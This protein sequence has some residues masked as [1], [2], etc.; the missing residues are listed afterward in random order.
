MFLFKWC[1]KYADVSPAVRELIE[2]C[3]GTCDIWFC[4]QIF[5]WLWFNLSL[6]KSLRCEQGVSTKLCQ[7]QSEPFV[8]TVKCKYLHSN[9]TGHLSYLTVRSASIFFRFH[10]TEGVM[11][12]VKRKMDGIS[13][14]LFQL[15]WFGFCW[16]I[17]SFLQCINIRAF[18]RRIKYS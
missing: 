5:V 3:H 17:I 14:R 2:N 10:T 1:F 15:S 6:S 8:Q 18:S 11:F 16:K 9:N 12:H 4:Y 7:L 13:Y